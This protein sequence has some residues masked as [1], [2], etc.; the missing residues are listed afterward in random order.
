MITDRDI[1]MAAFTKGRPLTSLKV[2]DAMAKQVTTCSA[3]SSAETA[4][5]LMKEVRVRRL[6][7][8]D[9]RGKLAGILSLNDLARE[10][11][12]EAR[13]GLTQVRPGD[14]ADTMGIICAHRSLP[15]RVSKP[16]ARG[17]GQL[18]GAAS[19]DRGIALP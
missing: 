9:A 6:P 12:K 16:A 10:A 15:P 4:M 14:V 1:C 5:S 7:I 13:F 19:E 8:V 17:T 18:V 2:R 11:R 3:E